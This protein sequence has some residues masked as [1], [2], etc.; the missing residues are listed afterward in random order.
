MKLLQKNGT[1]AFFCIACLLLAISFAFSAYSY[2]AYVSRADGNDTSSGVATIDCEV[3]V[4]NGGYGSFINAPIFQQVTDSTRPVQMNSWAE[5]VIKLS[6]KGSY[7]LRYEYG[8]VFYMPKSFADNAMFQFAEL[9]GGEYV[10]GDSDSVLRASKMY[11]ISADTA[12][13]GSIVETDKT[14]DGI[15]IQNDYKELIEAGDELVMDI[16]HS[17]AVIQD[18]A[19]K[20]N[21]KHTYATYTSIGGSATDNMF[22]CPVTFD[23]DLDMSFY[24]ITFNVARDGE[25]YVLDEN[26]SHY[27]LFRLVLRSSLDSGEFSTVWNVDD[28]WNKDASG[29]YTT[30]KQTPV[31]TDDFV[32][33]WAESGGAPML[34]S[35]GK[36]QLQIA[37]ADAADVWQNVSVRN[38]IGVTS[39]CGIGMVFS[40]TT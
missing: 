25:R 17:S 27:F 13:Y 32:C 36:P 24:R 7:G 5:T 35:D 14:V 20:G 6:N 39:P 38:C 19:K 31:V 21:V 12:E 9:A 40:Q 37:A 1:K 4:N 11:S 29:N 18:G 26:E 23:D 30:A 34:G 28:Y 15:T 2:A 22:V 8:F 3:T 16:A 33:R 10:S